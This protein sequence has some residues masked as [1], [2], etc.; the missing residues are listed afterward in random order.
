[1]TALAPRGWLAQLLHR[2]PAAWLAALDAWSYRVAQ[3]QMEK[4]RQ[5][6]RPAAPIDYKIKPWRD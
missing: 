2:M 3:R 5:A 6:A 4:R 1:M